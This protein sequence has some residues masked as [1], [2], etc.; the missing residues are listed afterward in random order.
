MQQRP[1]SDRLSSLRVKLPQMAQP[2][3]AMLSL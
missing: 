2:I 3:W 1:L